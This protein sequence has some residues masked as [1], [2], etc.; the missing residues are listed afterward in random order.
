M[1]AGKLLEIHKKDFHNTICEFDSCNARDVA[2]LAQPVESGA[3]LCIDYR[4]LLEKM[5]KLLKETSKKTVLVP[6]I[7]SNGKI[8][9]E[10]RSRDF[11]LMVC[12]IMIRGETSILKHLDDIALKSG[13]KY[14]N[15]ILNELQDV[16][17][18]HNELIKKMGQGQKDADTISLMC[19]G[20]RYW[21]DFS[22]QH[23][24][25]IREKKA[26]RN[27]IAA[28]AIIIFL[29]A[30]AGTYLYHEF[31]DIPIESVSLQS[32]AYYGDSIE[33]GQAYNISVNVTP[34]DSN[35]SD[36]QWIAEPSTGVSLKPTSSGLSV[37]I[38]PS[39]IGSNL[40]IHAH[41]D[42]YS[43]DSNAIIL[44]VDKTVNFERSGPQ[45]ALR[46]NQEFTIQ[47]SL[48]KNLDLDWEW[49]QSCVEK[50][51]TD[52]NAFT[53]RVLWTADSTEI[54]VK[55]KLRGSPTFLDT[56]NLT[57]S[58]L[59][60]INLDTDNI[61]LAAGSNQYVTPTCS[62]GYYDLSSIRWD[63]PDWIKLGWD[64]VR[65]L[66]T[67]SPVANEH[68]HGKVR[69]FEKNVILAQF[70]VF[71]TEGIGFSFTVDSEDSLT[72][73]S[74]YPLKAQATRSGLDLSSMT[75]STSSEGVSIVGTG[76]SVKMNLAGELPAG[77]PIEVIATYYGNNYVS[78]FTVKNGLEISLSTNV[79]GLVAGQTIT[80][81]ADIPSP[82][83]SYKVVWALGDTTLETGVNPISIT[84]PMD[85]KLGRSYVLSAHLQGAEQF[86][87]SRELPVVKQVEL[88]LSSSLESITAASSFSQTVVLNMPE[89]SDRVKWHLEENNSEAVLISNTGMFASG[90]VPLG[91][92]T[93]TTFK[94]VGEIPESNVSVSVTYTVN[95]IAFEISSTPENIAA[96]STFQLQ[97]SGVPSGYS[98]TYIWSSTGPITVVT[99]GSLADIE[100]SPFVTEPCTAVVTAAIQGTEYSVSRTIYISQVGMVIDGLSSGQTY[101]IPSTI[102]L[103]TVMNSHNQNTKAAI[104]IE[105]RTN[106]LKI[107]LSDLSFS[108]GIVGGNVKNGISMKSPSSTTLVTIVA[109]GNVNI[110]AKDGSIPIVIPNLILSLSENSVMTLTG[111]NGDNG[112]NAT[113]S[114]TSGS[115]GK[116]GMPAIRSTN[117][118]QIIGDGSL[119]ATGGNGGN[120]GNGYSYGSAKSGRDGGSGGNGGN[121]G[122]ALECGFLFVADSVTSYV[123]G[124]NGGNGGNGGTGDSGYT[125]TAGSNST[126]YHN[127]VIHASPGGTGGKGGNG[128]NGGNG[129]FPC[130]INGTVFTK[131]LNGNGGNGGNGGTGGKGGNGGTTPNSAWWVWSTPVP[132][133]GGNG[134]NGGDGGFGGAPGTGHINGQHGTNGTGGPG[135]LGGKGSTVSNTFITSQHWYG[136][137]G[138]NG[139]SGTTYLSNLMRV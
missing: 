89:Y 113:Y 81:T 41:S 96:G 25:D 54:P 63:A 138:I 122:T 107:V 124:G 61:S 76:D 128:G 74:S 67:F 126:K 86:N 106:P 8:T 31:R 40:K 101:S 120:G 35:T 133:N 100:V 64:G 28:C 10:S 83:A 103:V 12:T 9:L 17:E 4:Q 70:D 34:S 135:G 30:C 52:K 26:K 39:F 66:V 112:G 71:V 115:N 58:E 3:S 91:T 16:P 15:K 136:K 36:I 99:N 42:R 73:G 79:D 48:D 139:S 78:H 117:S 119:S 65:Q 80:A 60:N 98:P 44:Q 125:G 37:S 131:S 95:P 87:T 33:L 62:V 21:T 132:S 51:K 102:N 104:V 116:P 108:S 1:I 82:L 23:N 69:L 93:S 6:R 22:P 5:D 43:V 27:K 137:N 59:L 92:G 110:T 72:A 11:A 105:D 109:N 50:I 29:I 46:L 88:S 121:G 7:Y 85:A 129:G 55:C 123:C 134:G 84:V 94:L 90:S 24:A 20:V 57:V 53:G 114:N 45:D 14:T 77:A 2:A 118:L 47:Y 127:A 18:Y 111:S 97:L 19:T 68:D 56:Y 13:V 38:D 75:W 130:S 32:D 49:P